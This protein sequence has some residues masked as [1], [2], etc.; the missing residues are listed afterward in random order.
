MGASRPDATGDDSTQ[1]FNVFGIGFDASVPATLTFNTQVIP[2]SIAEP[3]DQLPPT[4]TFTLPAD[5]MTDYF[6][7]TFKSVAPT[8][9]IQMT[10]SG[11]DCQ[12]ST[13]IKFDPSAPYTPEPTLPD[14]AAVLP[15]ASVDAPFPIVP[16]ALILVF[17]GVL[18]LSTRLL[19][20][21]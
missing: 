3:H 17:T 19:R 12:T 13:V 18:I 20:S 14:T 8:Q 11:K 16:V 10:I 7:W 6:K 5:Y 1:W 21:F 15:A 2:Y 9:T 4:N